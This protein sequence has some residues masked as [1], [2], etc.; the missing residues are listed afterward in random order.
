MTNLSD[1]IAQ[2]SPE[3]REL[4]LQRLQSSNKKTASATIQPQSRETN[5]FPLSFAQ[6]RLWFLA[7]LE[8]DNPVYN[9][10]RAFRLAGELNLEVLKL[11]F[12]EIIRRHENLRTNFSLVDGEPVQIIQ[13]QINFEIPVV[14]IESLSS[15]AEV[16][17]IVDQEAKKPFNLEQDSLLRVTLL[18]LSNLE[19]MVLFTTHHII[20]DGWSNGV[21][22]KEFVTLYLAFLEGKPSPLPELAIQYADYAVWQRNYLRGKVWDTQLNYWQQQLGNT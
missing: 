19:H 8:P 11:T 17:K 2:L 4:L 7:R 13:P 10:P 9:Q 6:K 1:R 20:S 18:K 22:I 14:D 16:Q 15:E 3:K 21:L 5:T 12:Q